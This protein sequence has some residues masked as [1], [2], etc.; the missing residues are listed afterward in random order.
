MSPIGG[1][2]YLNSTLVSL[3]PSYLVVL[4]IG[5]LLGYL[6]RR[7][8]PPVL[9]LFGWMT[10]PVVSWYVGFTASGRGGIALLNAYLE[11]P[12][13]GFIG[14]GL[15]LWASFASSAESRKKRDM[16]ALVIL[17]LAA[18]LMGALI[19]VLGENP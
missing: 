9:L 7:D 4:A 19:P 2:D 6:V 8:W 14:M 15:Y 16:A 1:T 13:L 12:L 17:N 5:V 10:T 11:P 3:V 18:V